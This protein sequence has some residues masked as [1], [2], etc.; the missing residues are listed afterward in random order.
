MV[1]KRLYEVDLSGYFLPPNR[2]PMIGPETGRQ[3]QNGISKYVSPHGSARY[4]YYQSEKGGPLSCRS[5][6]K[7]DG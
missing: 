3:V 4:V 7:T 6:P 5:F 1:K 2:V